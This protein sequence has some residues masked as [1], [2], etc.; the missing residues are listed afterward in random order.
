MTVRADAGPL[1]G[2]R[3]LE[4]DGPLTAHAGRL[5]WELGADVV[6]VEP[7][8]GSPM[9]GL[10]QGAV[11]AHHHAGKVAIAVDPTCEPG[12]GRVAALLAG[13]DVVIEGTTPD[14]L[15][16]D[17]DRH[18]RAGRGRP[19]PRARRVLPVRDDGSAA[20]TRP[21]PISSS[22]R[23]AASWRRSVGRTRHRRRPPAI[24]PGTSPRS[25]PRSAC[26][27]RSPLGA[28]PDTVRRSRSPRSSAW[29]PAWRRARSSTSTPTMS[30]TGPAPRTRSRRIASSARPTAGW[31][32]DSVAIRA[33]GTGS[34]TGWRKP[35][36][37]A[38]SAATNCAIPRCRPSN[39]SACST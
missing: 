37:S 36:R 13:A 28:V 35:T 10:A 6:L 7:A 1:S 25:T 38:T 39:A 9:R 33:C 24:R 15:R 8:D 34:S 22:A 3:V 31:R 19:G 21:R 30:R 12:R 26:C 14:S 4:F 11:F 16:P 18:R 23:S 29:P 5:L 17:A 2:I 27:S 20:P 32:A